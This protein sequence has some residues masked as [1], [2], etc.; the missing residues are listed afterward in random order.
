MVIEVQITIKTKDKEIKLSEGEA[1]EI[2]MELDKMFNKPLMYT[3]YIPSS[4]Y[5]PP[6]SP[7]PII[8][9]FEIES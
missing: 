4:P 1:R 6:I 9:S 5:I 3:P 7:Y 2:W 8:T